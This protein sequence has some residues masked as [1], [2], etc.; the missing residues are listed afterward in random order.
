MSKGPAIWQQECQCKR[1]GEY[2]KH[3]PRPQTLTVV[4]GCPVHDPNLKKY[5]PRKVN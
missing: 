2:R 4:T 3:G 1:V 5:P